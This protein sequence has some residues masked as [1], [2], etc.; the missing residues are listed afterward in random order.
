[1]AGHSKWSQIKH[2]KAVEDSKKSKLFSA[3]AQ[4]I[5][6]EAR[7]V[8]GDRNAP[9]LR[10]A[11]EKARQNNMPAENIERAIKRALGN[12]GGGEEVFYETYGP[13]R[14]ALVIK[15][16]TSNKNRTNQEIKHLL[17]KHEVN[18]SAPGSVIWAF[19]KTPD[20]KFQA[21]HQVT[22]NP[23]DKEKLQQLIEALRA[24]SDITEI[25]T[26]VTGF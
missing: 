4:T 20:G 15:G 8:R 14:V 26:N 13:G 12:G 7:L 24:H 18:L 11:I 25:L 21:Q 19:Q 1:M 9:G 5:I 16:I 17:A 2:Q 23:E 10:Q 6:T 22:V 3:L